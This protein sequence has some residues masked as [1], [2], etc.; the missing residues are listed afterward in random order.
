MAHGKNGA[1]KGKE[2]PLRDQGP[3]RLLRVAQRYQLR[4]RHDSVLAERDLIETWVI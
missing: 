4:E 3:A 2:V 1:V